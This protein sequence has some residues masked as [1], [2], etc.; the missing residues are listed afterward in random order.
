MA[1]AAALIEGPLMSNHHRGLWGYYGEAHA[2]AP[3]TVQSTGIGGPSTAVVLRE[4]AALGVKRAVRIGTCVAIQ[5]GLALGDLVVIRGAMALDGTSAALGRS[6]VLEGNGALTE[7]VL[8][9]L[10]DAREGI[11]ATVDLLPVDDEALTEGAIAID[12]TTAPLLAL[13]PDIGIAAAAILVV[14]A[15]ADGRQIRDDVLESSSLT[16]AQAALAGMGNL[17]ARS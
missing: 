15:A 3:L 9:G 12:L 16:A 2:G 17:D 1:L 8:A 6:G 14:A 11:V 13:A 4:L 7:G 10:A 5:P